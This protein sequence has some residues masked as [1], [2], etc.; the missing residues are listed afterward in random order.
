MQKY[1]KRFKEQH[2]FRKKTCTQEKIYF[3]YCTKSIIFTKKRTK[4]SEAPEVNILKPR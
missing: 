3:L 4:K 1:K 2:F